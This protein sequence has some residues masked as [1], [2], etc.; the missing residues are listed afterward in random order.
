MNYW[1][2]AAGTAS[3]I[4]ML[5][6]IFLGGR[7]IVRPLLAAEGLAKVPKFTMYYCWHLVT[8]A[9]LALAAGFVYAGA[10]GGGTDIV[11]AAISGAVLFCGWSLIMIVGFG[12]RVLHFPQWIMFATV[13]VFGICGT[14][15]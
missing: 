13:V 5:I 4:T 6:H 7:E 3:L 11:V 1:F 2:L 15:L 9:I 14:I 12:L 8:I 10:F